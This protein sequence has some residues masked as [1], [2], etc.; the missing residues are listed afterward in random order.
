MARIAR[1]VAPGVPHL[2]TQRGNRQQPTFFSDDDF[3]LYKELVGAFCAQAGVE[4]WAYS[5]MPNHVN[6][7]LVPS[8]EDGLQAG[9]GEAHRRYTRHINLRENWRGYLWQGRFAS[10][11]L[12][13]DYLDIATRYVELNPVRARLARK[14]K[15][16]K[17]CS[18]RAHLK[19]KPDGFVDIEP[20]RERFGAWKPFLNG[21]MSEDQ[22]ELLR[23]HERTG[24][25][26][27]S[28]AFISGLE[29]SLG[30]SLKKN[31]PGPKPKPRPE[32]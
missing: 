29:K 20:L 3:V 10:F 7:L 16:Y 27:G 30:R 8:S 21:P 1:V 18:A 14:P 6:L 9:L 13:E 25:P 28:A 2:V 12:E 23:A 15:D 32:T 17:W 26:L 19:D 24:R 4:I 31:K 22:M 5:L 11:P